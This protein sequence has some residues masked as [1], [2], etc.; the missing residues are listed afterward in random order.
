[1]TDRQKIYSR[2]LKVIKKIMK[3]HKQGHVVTLAMMITGIVSGRK[4]QLSVMSSEAF[5]YCQRYEH[6][7]TYASFCKKQICEGR[8]LLYAVCAFHI[9]LAF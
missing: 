9:M 6:R 7:K 2:V 5:A 3:N 4:A 8:R 1:M